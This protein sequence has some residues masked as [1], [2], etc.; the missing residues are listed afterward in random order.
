MFTGIVQAIGTI[1]SC[2]KAPGLLTVTI[3][4]PDA[5]LCDIDPGASVAVNG[6]CLTVAAMTGSALQF[7]IVAETLQVSNL[8][9]L[10][11]GSKVN[12]ERSLRYGDEVGGHLLSGH[13]DGCAEIVSV[14]E[15]ENNRRVFY[16]VPTGYQRYIYHKGFVALDGCSLTV[17]SIHRDKGLFSVCFIPETL[18]ATTHGGKGPGQLINLEIDRQTQVIS[19][20]VERI[21][22]ERDR[23]QDS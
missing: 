6:V 10:G 2:V 12:V 1:V 3:D 9:L 11:V 18:R 22:A 14:D 16:R 20:T 5:L 8:S 23:A 17:A 21:L 7:D 15:E 4:L 19:D 13:V